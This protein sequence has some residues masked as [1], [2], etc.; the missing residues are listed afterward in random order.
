MPYVRGY[1]LGTDSASGNDG[2]SFRSVIKSLANAGGRVQVGFTAPSGAV[3]KVDHA[4]VGVWNGTASQ[5]KSVPN[6]LLFAGVS[7]FNIASRTII[8]SDFVALTDLWTLSDS[9]VVTVDIAASGG[10][11]IAYSAS[12]GDGAYDKTGA[13]YNL[14]NP[15]GMVLLSATHNISAF[16][17]GNLPLTLRSQNSM[18]GGF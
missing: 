6:E 15:A 8:L 7:G 14:A 4:S 11:G 13:T 12:N 17:V 1:L 2:L 9:L 5:T 3:C 18:G 16:A 10:G